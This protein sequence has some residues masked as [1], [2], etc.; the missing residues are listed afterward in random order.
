MA[1]RRIRSQAAWTV[2][3]LTIS[4]Q[5]SLG[6][7]QE[8][9][10]VSSTS[11]IVVSVSGIAS[12][13]GASILARGGNA[14]DAAVATAFALAVTHPS[15]GNLGGGG[16]MVIRFPDG[17]A[18]TIDYRER[19]PLRAT[20][21][22]YLDADGRIDRSLTNSGWLASGVPGTVRGLELAHRKYGRLP[23]ADVV[24]PAAELAAR[25]W[26]LS[27][28]L[29][30]SLNSVLRGK[31]SRFESSVDAYGKPGGG[32]WEAGDTIRL[33]DLARTLAAIAAG[34]GDVFY[35]G[36]IADSIDAQMQANGGLV[37]KEDLAQY[38][39]VERP[40]VEGTFLGH[41]IISMGP[42]SSGGTVLIETLNILERL[43]VDRLE[44]GSPEFMH[45]RIEAARL[46]YLDRARYLGDP[47]FVPVPL[48]R[49]LSKTYA[50]SLA[51]SIPSDRAASSIDLGR[52]IVT[53]ASSRE[54]EETTHFSVVDA[55]GMAVSNTYTLE[56]SYGS[57]VVV[58]GTGI[59]LNNEMGD[60]NKKPGETNVLGDIGTEPNLIAPGKRMLSSMTPTI[61]ERGGQLLLVTGSPGGRTIPNTVIDVVLGVTAFGLSLEEAVDA[62]RLH[63]QWLPDTTTIEAGGASE[64]AL[65]R[66]RAMGHKVGS[67]RGLGQGDAHSILYD[68]ATGTAYGVNDRRSPDSKA[69]KPK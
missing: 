10:T 53:V 57:G 48:E 40:P 33:P 47:D 26:P 52:D 42:P 9:R 22:M 4:A 7:A 45:R 64:E 20:P 24:R 15:A 29:A 41:K 43:G 23:W 12:D 55:D 36:W 30:R 17:R 51:A 16:F 68:A 14:V 18:T 5:V 58:R 1:T 67:S 37:T 13:V 6:T 61:V 59:L 60:F 25:G 8:S 39:A 2:F 62:P 21:T 32:D 27:P 69:S 63:H 65:Q 38:R 49:L 66:L 46:A 54:S 11:G 28:A 44:R 19:A 35:H 31:F 34:G 56:A 3:A 50:D